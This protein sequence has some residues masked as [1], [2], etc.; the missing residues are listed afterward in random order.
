MRDPV[1]PE[2]SMQCN[3]I[4]HNKIRDTLASK[5]GQKGANFRKVTLHHNISFRL[6]KN[7]TFANETFYLHIVGNKK[8]R[9]FN[10]S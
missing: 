4:N 9:A 5:P 2:F 10:Y 8:S 1:L 6:T 7:L 3:H